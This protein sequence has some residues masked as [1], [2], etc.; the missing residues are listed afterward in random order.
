M[1]KKHVSNVSSLRLHLPPLPIF[2]LSLSAWRFNPSWQWNE[3]GSS[4]AKT[5]K[6]PR[7]H[8]RKK[9]ATSASNK[10]SGRKTR[11]WSSTRDCARFGRSGGT[12][13]IRP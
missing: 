8:R 12:N 5:P 4:M 7:R 9:G 10:G 6:P 13:S 11:P 3:T 2:H 1:Y